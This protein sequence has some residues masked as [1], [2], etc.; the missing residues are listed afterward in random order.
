MSDNDF[1]PWD[2]TKDYYEKRFYDVRLPDGTIVEKCWP[3]AGRM[4]ATDGSG[5]KWVSGIEVR[6]RP[7]GEWPPSWTRRIL[8]D[9]K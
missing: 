1:K 8:R 6:P 4:V 3:N 7:K 9:A 2:G 5:R